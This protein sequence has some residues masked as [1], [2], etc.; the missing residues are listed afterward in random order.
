MKVGDLVGVHG[1]IGLVLKIGEGSRLG[2]AYVGWLGLGLKPEWDSIS[3][4]EVISE[5]R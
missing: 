5:S 3:L 4:L 2:Y 1:I